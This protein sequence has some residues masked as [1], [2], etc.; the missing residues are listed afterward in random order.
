MILE[1]QI[2][3]HLIYDVLQ[4][5]SAIELSEASSTTLTHLGYCVSKHCLQSHLFYPHIF[6]FLGATTVSIFFVF[7][8]AGPL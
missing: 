1:L 2:H 4:L 7:K 5:P 6:K 3:M 8:I